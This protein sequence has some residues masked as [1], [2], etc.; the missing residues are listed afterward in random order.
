[1]TSESIHT[2]EELIRVA[3]E[4]WILAWLKPAEKAGTYLHNLLERVRGQPVRSATVP[5]HRSRHS[6]NH[7]SPSST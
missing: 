4:G 7:K 1:M 6:K 5:F 2:L 3:G